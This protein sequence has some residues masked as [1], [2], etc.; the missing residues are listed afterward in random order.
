MSSNIS[1]DNLKKGERAVIKE[2]ISP[3]IPAKFYEMGFI[4]GAEVELKHKAPLSGPICFSI[5]SNNSL[6][7]IRRSEAKVI[8]IDIK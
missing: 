7:A 2:F 6:I 3:E 4:P 8:I 1:L 5:L